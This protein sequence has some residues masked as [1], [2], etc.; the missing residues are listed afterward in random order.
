MIHQTVI[1]AKAPNDLRKLSKPRSQIVLSLTCKHCLDTH[2]LS[3]KPQ[4]LL[5]IDFLKE[6][7]MK[8]DI[9]GIQMI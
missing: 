6:V 4:W 3:N 5:Y 8:K 2:T 9:L 7:T 1:K